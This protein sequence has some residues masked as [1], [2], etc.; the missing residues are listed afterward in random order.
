MPDHPFG[1][2]PMLF[3]VIIQSSRGPRTVRCCTGFHRTATAGTINLTP[4]GRELFA[5][6]LRGA[7]RQPVPPAFYDAFNHDLEP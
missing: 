3:D 2:K 1:Q 7:A 4:H 6:Y 5:G